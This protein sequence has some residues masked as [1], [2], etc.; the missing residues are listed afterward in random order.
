MYYSVIVLSSW[1]VINFIVPHC[2]TTS[3]LNI[4][5]SCPLTRFQ[6]GIVKSWQ[7]CRQLTEFIWHIMHT[8]T[9]TTTQFSRYH[10][11]I[12][13]KVKLTTDF[14]QSHPTHHSGGRKQCIPWLSRVASFTFTLLTQHRASHTGTSVTSPRSCRMTQCW[15]S[16]HRPTRTKESQKKNTYKKQVFYVKKY[17]PSTFLN[18]FINTETGKETCTKIKMLQVGFV[19][20]IHC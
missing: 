4:I 19:L 18:S 10:W 12:F 13:D 6:E 9:T 7:L 11:S 1:L 2:C 8:K 15:A 3:I 16:M 17:S 20:T 14:S 5:N